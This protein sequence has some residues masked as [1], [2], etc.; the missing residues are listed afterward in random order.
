[1]TNFEQLKR[2]GAISRGRK[3]NGELKQNNE[4][5]RVRAEARRRA[6]LVLQYNHRDEFNALIK[7]ELTSM[8]NPDD[9]THVDIES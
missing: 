4:K 7:Q 6:S 3:P 1:M 5:Y 9:A 2:D 8:T